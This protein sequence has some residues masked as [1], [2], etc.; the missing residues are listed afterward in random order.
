MSIV[1]KLIGFWNQLG[2]KT[3]TVLDEEKRPTVNPDKTYQCPEHLLKQMQEI[4]ARR[5]GIQESLGMLTQELGKLYLK[6]KTVWD[7]IHKELGIPKDVGLSL[8]RETGVIKEIHFK[9]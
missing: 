1:G 2:V 5:N 7:D 4:D 9:E 6:E 3:I 8:N